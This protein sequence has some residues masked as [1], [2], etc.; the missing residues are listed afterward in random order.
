M[1]KYFGT[2][3]KYY[4]R[5]GSGTAALEIARSTEYISPDDFRR[6]D[7]IATETAKTLWGP[8]I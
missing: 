5:V 2:V 8:S 7:D 3:R 1:V 4:R 6:L